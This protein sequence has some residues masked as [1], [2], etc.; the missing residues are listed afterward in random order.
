MEMPSIPHNVIHP[1]VGYCLVRQRGEYWWNNSQALL[2]VKFSSGEIE[3]VEG[4]F[5]VFLEEE[6]VGD[7]IVRYG[8]VLV[9]H[10]VQMGDIW[11]MQTVAFPKGHPDESLSPYKMIDTREIR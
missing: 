7:V 8:N 6:A 9:R 4:G 5:Y 1:D 10:N 11:L 2:E 3:P